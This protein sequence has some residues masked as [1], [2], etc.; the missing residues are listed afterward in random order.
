MLAETFFPRKPANTVI[1][2][3]QNEYP[4]PACKTHKI[5]KEQIRRQLKRLKPYKAPGPDGIPNIVLTQC[6]DLLVDRLWYIYNAILVKEIY[7]SPWKHSITVVLRKPGKPRYDTPKAYRPIAL[8][9]TLGKL[10]TAIIAEQL[11]YYAEKYALLPPTHFGGR[12]GRTTTDA[13]HTLTYKIKDAW[14]KR[15]VVSVLFLDIEGAFPNAVN[16]RL[17]HNL[18]ARKVP[19]KLVKFIHNLLKD[20]YTALKFD[21][22]MSEAIELDNGIGQGDLLS[23]ILYQFY[24]ADLLNI[25]N[26]TKEAASAYVDDAILVATAK[27]F[28]GAHEILVDMMTRPGGAIDWSHKHNSR[29]EFSKLALIDFA[30]RNSAKERPNLILPNITI[31]P[32]RSTKYLGVYVDQHLSWNTHI[33]YTLKKGAEWSSQIRRVAAPSWGLTPKHARKMYASVA[34]PR[35]LYAADIWGIPKPIEGRATHKKGTS[36]AIAKL[37]STQR[38]GALAVTGGLRTTP[39][40]VLDMHAHLMPIHL[41]IDKICH[42]AATR[43]ATLPP[44]HPLHKPAKKCAGHRIKRHRSPLHQL[45]SIY[46]IRPQDVESIVPASRNPA[47]THRRPFTVSFASSKDNSVAEDTLATEKVKVYSDGSA[48][49]GKVGAA[50]LLLREGAP[51][52]TLHYHLGPSSL[53]TVHEAELVGLLLGLHL[54]RT[55]RRGRTSFAIGADNQAALSALNSVKSTT[56]QYIANEIIETA[57]N[58]KKQRNSNNYSLAFRWTA[59]H[60]GIKGN[61]EVDGK[62]KKAA[63]GLSSAKKELP[64]LLRKPLKHNKAA[65]RQQRRDVLKARWKKEWEAST[66]ANKFK[67]LDFTAPSDKFIKL[68]SDDKLSRKDAS[69]IFQ[70]R[71]G[72]V[73]LNAYLERFKR[74]ERASCPA[75]GHPKEDT[76]HFL[77]DC[78]AY[79]HERWALLQ[80]CKTQEPKMKDILNNGDMAVPLANFIQATGR[81]EQGETQI[82]NGGNRH[83]QEIGSQPRIPRH[84]GPT[85]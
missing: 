56:G 14:R 23:M 36:V 54:I 1:E 70:L 25:P 9:N 64:P 31:E 21:D 8:L 43:I 22:F 16:E 59:G 26:G 48:Q 80:H 18:K 60:V 3:G 35:I 30:H 62:A 81:F 85:N 75:C 42:R 20:R 65:L 44:T 79:R 82:Q 45:M 58:I 10:L 32:S 84:E 17:E 24:N 55:E 51:D 29:F 4:P 38:A 19:S 47:I 13:L 63:E 5:S 11:T 12:P 72:H 76:Q 28:E 57:A 6:A 39:T 50:A 27:D 49:N 74:A 61:E 41:E 52:R 33:A 15:Q 37:T 77:F 69:R 67:A 7:Y 40:D 73:P 34:I 66:R 46:N 2:A 78:P 83:R 53:H 68:I 71:T